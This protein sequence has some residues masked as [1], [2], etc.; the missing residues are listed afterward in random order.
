V[1]LPDLDKDII[2][3]SGILS[4]INSAH[5]NYPKA[6]LSTQSAD[7][8]LQV[9][10]L[11][12]N[13]ASINR[14]MSRKSNAKPPSVNRL[15]FLPRKII[16]LWLVRRF[17]DSSTTDSIDLLGQ[18]SVVAWRSKWWSLG[19]DISFCHSAIDDEILF[20]KSVSLSNQTPNPAPQKKREHIPDH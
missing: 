7:P 19:G 12:K 1:N 11:W 3:T 18:K 15:I 20:P 16:A 10:A 9:I 14:S 4:R 2:S 8:R 17:L 5:R 6:K 13:Q